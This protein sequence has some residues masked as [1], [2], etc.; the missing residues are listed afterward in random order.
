MSAVPWARRTLANAVAPSYFTYGCHVP[1]GSASPL[2]MLA[3]L[4]TGSTLR[5]ASCFRWPLARLP[6]IVGAKAFCL[7]RANIVEGFRRQGYL[8]IGSGTVDWFK[9][10][11][12][13][14][15][16]LVK[17]FD[18]FHFAGNALSLPAQLHWLDECMEQMLPDQPRFVFLNL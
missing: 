16:F 10:S 2:V 5:L 9:A 13:T 18:F 4:I 12:D 15:S 7:G 3:V 1:F 17:P 11:T 14:G 6:G 8:T